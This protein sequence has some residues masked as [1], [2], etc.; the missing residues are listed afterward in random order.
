M[1]GKAGR[2]APP[3]TRDHHYVP[4][5]VLRPWRRLGKL[6]GYYKS[7][8]GDIRVRKLGVGA[9]CKELDLLSLKASG[10][11]ADALERDFFGA[12]DDCGAKARDALLRDGALTSADKRCDFAR[13]LLS[14]DA[15]RPQLVARLRTEVAEQL[16]A[17]VDLDDEVIAAMRDHG[18][19]QAPSTYFEERTGQLF[20]DRALLIM[21]GL[22]DNPEVGSYLINAHWRVYRLE[23][24]NGSFLLGDRP[25][26][27]IGGYSSEDCLWALP[28]LPSAVFV[29]ANAAST[30][31]KLDGANGPLLRQR[32]NEFT[33]N[34]ID[35]YVFMADE[36]NLPFVTER[37]QS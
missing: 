26:V 10:L 2:R 25:L 34:Q 24:G 28:L 14:L 3:L 27:R 5:F 6:W 12:V 31:A 15:R 35:R 9:F 19:A 8:R 4:R 7:M 11:R 23:P 36:S 30:A 37:L 17:S 16:R 13:L 22:V 29:A 33:M 18:I 32:I 1:T 21:Q 20:D